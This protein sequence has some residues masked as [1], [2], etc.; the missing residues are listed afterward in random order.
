MIKMVRSDRLSGTEKKSE[1][2]DFLSSQVGRAVIDS[3]Q[4]KNV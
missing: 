4:W 1:L 3:S 2:V